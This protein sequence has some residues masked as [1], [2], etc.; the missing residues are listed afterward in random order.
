MSAT[1]AG[2]NAV[3]DRYDGVLLDLDGT[4]FRGSLPTSGAV[5]SL[6]HLRARR[7][8]VCFITNNAS[9][10]P[11]QVAEH[12]RSLGFTAD[13]AHVV[14]SAQAGASLLAEHVS[15]G[16]AV[17][18]V[19]TEALADEVR[20]VGLTAVRRFD[21]RPVA[22]VQGHSPD[23]AWADLAQACLA[24]RAG[25]LWVACNVDPTLPTEIGELPGN[26]AMVAALRAA[27]GR[28][29][30]VAGKPQ[31]RLMDLGSSRLR[32]RKPLVVGDRLD[33]D[34][35]GAHAAGMDALLV[36]SGV[37]T[38]AELLAAP[39]QQRPRYVAADLT[40]LLQPASTAEMGAQPDWR[41]QR[42]GGSA[43]LSYRGADGS[44][45]Q[46]LVALRALCAALWAEEAGDVPVKP[47]DDVA[48]AALE[49]LG[50]G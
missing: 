2:G 43:T 37:A 7:R 12:L 32:L 3:A 47:S 4:A 31:R 45:A 28:E 33:T 24:I 21:Q 9:R 35:A 40:S 30:L 5:E 11:A 48:R 49:T 41:V 20:G 19:G 1:P 17:L 38:P 36:L 13:A 42:S 39:P 29:P 46:P 34:I 16:D 14:T 25:T 27:T 22:V 44:A 8:A 23:T 15:P 50:L 18:V 6:A 10:S 26:G